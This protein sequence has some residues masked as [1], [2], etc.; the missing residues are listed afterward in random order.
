MSETRHDEKVEEKQE[1]QEEK[2]E[3]GRGGWEEKWRRDP[4]NA[5][6]WA[7]ILIW[8]GVVL[9]VENAGLLARY[10]GWEAWSFILLGAGVIVLLK[11]V[12]SAAVPEYRR[13]VGG[14]IVLG[15][16][17]IG[18]GLGDLVGWTVVGPLVLIA[19]GI[20]ILLRGMVGR[21]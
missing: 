6:T 3:K 1:K 17:L 13:P 7:A 21:R 4:L 18:V 14:D 5:I 12:V 8:A 20:S 15:F 11:A 9:L 16:I 2:D 19:I 10:E